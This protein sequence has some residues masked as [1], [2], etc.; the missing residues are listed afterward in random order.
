M[1]DSVATQGTTIS[2]YRSKRQKS[3]AISSDGD[4][5]VSQPPPT[6]EVPNAIGPAMSE[7]VRTAISLETVAGRSSDDHGRT[8]TSP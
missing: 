3:R 2:R 1:M 5:G 8:S 7:P 6:I 4:A